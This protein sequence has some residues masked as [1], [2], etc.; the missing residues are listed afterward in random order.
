M[1]ILLQAADRDQS[2][3]H[4][5]HL[6]AAFG[7]N[8]GDLFAAGLE[9]LGHHVDRGGIETSA[10]P[11]HKG[12]EERQGQ[13]DGQND[14]HALPRYAVDGNAPAQFLHRGV[15]HVQT[16][17]APGEIG[18]GLSRREAGLKDHLPQ[19]GVVRFLLGPE[20]PALAR[21]SQ[22]PSTV[23]TTPIIGD[24]DL[25]VAADR[26]RSEGDAPLARFAERLAVAGASR[27]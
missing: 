24:R 13:R 3:A 7:R 5:H 22:N 6:G 25:N 17:A 14:L 19:G 26:R 9:D 11:H 21:M 12:I 4:P 10:D 16:D 15:E 18:H 20:Q 1:V 2:V 8:A 23:E 27:P